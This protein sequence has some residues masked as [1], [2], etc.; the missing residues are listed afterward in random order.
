MEQEKALTLAN[1]LNEKNFNAAFTIDDAENYR[2]WA[3]DNM[4]QFFRNETNGLQGVQ[5]VQLEPEYNGVRDNGQIH[6]GC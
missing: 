1:H 4:N 6:S 5:S 2:E 3:D